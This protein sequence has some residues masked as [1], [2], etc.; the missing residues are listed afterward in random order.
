MSL[1]NNNYGICSCVFSQLLQSFEVNKTLKLFT[2]QYII[3]NQH[4]N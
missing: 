4:R 2:Y 3:I 1:I